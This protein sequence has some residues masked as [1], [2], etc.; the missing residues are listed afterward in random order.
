MTAG[1]RARTASVARILQI[2]WED[3]DLPTRE[4]EDYGDEVL[5]LSA[6]ATQH[7]GG[8]VFEG[9][10]AN[11]KPV[12]VYLYS[13]SADLEKTEKLENR[14]FGDDDLAMASRF[15]RCVRV[16]ADAIRSESLRREYAP[17]LPA[18]YLLDPDGKVLTRKC[19][20]ATP[21][22]L[23]GLLR[24][25]Y[26]ETYGKSLRP[27]LTRLEKYLDRLEETE[28]AVLE[29]EDE[30]NRLEDRLARRDNRRM[31]LRLE[32][33]RKVVAQ[34]RAK[35]DEVK[36]EEAKVLAPPAAEAADNDN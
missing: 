28:T 13:A 25:G 8:I 24:R 31:R 26:R 1:G 5:P 17:R 14:M 10:A 34:L 12:L 36:K 33:A 6:L 21:G 11:R 22:N 3:R 16:D 4:R 27:R 18:F 29:A 9:E 30:V 7:A 2:R 19:G 15:F 20:R 23:V 35:L 32:E